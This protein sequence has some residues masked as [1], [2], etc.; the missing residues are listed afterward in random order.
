M[1]II[2]LTYKKSLDEVGRHLEAHRAFLKK[3]YTSGQLIMSGPKNP[4]TGGVILALTTLAEAERLAKEDPFY[5][6]GIA[7]YR[8]IEFIPNSHSEACAAVAAQDA[9][10]NRT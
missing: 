8:F 9:Q 7:E 4:R 1:I 10:L 3:H 2:E 6:H 5:E